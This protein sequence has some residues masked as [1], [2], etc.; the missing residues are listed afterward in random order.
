MKR[1]THLTLTLLLTLLCTCVRA[2]N[3]ITAQL[4]TADAE[5]I[6]YTNIALY[7][8][9]NLVKVETTNEAGIFRMQ[10]V[11]NGDYVLIATYLG[12]P[13]LTKNLS[14]TGDLDLGVLQM[15][16]A[17]IE[18]EAA[19]VTATRALVEIKPDRTV[20]NVQGTIN[21]VGENG[22]DLLRKAPGVTIDN[23][24]NI[25]VLSRS[26]VLV[27]VD[28]KR[29]PLAGADLADYLRN[30]TAE[31]IDRIDIIT[32]PGAK[33]APTARLTTPSVRAATRR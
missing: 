1:L 21:A 12:A 30:L 11:P 8:D 2:Q 24:D 14:I 10:Q 9:S 32:N 16:P 23:N 28:G 19:T 3:T 17:S 29:L 7:A 18:L 33:K 22:L 20:F 25:N 5:P 6:P 15:A 26:G 13:D 27:Y 31:Q 4:K